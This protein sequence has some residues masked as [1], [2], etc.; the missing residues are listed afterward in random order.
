MT[1]DKKFVQVGNFQVP[2]ASPELKVTGSS[3]PDFDDKTDDENDFSLLVAYKSNNPR[4]LG[5][6][7]Q[8]EWIRLRNKDRM[9]HFG[10]FPRDSNSPAKCTN[11]LCLKHET[12]ERRRFDMCKRCKEIFCSKE[13]QI[14]DHV[15]LPPVKKCQEAGKIIRA[16]QAF[17]DKCKVCGPA[18]A[19]HR[20]TVSD[21]CGF[22]PCEACS[23]ITSECM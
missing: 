4:L 21:T 12:T 15:H 3:V 19:K 6:E 9:P 5:E 1:S 23:K 14:K 22:K 8:K 20:I 16:N 2:L 11:L 18:Y 10:R 17:Y 13:C 7:Q